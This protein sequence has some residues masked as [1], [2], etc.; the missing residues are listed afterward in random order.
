M[1]R[2]I[3]TFSDRE[4]DAAALA[5]FESQSIA[6]QTV[7]PA[8]GYARV[9]RTAVV[10]SAQD[11]MRLYERNGREFACAGWAPYRDAEH[12]VP[13]ESPAEYEEDL[14]ERADITTIETC[15]ANP[16]KMRAIAAIRGDVSRALPYLNAILPDVSY[17]H[18]MPVLTFMDAYRMVSLYPQRVSVARS[19]DIVD[20]WRVLERL[21]CAV[22]QA[23]A[24]RHE[25]EPSYTLRVKPP[26]LE[27]FKRLPGT[28]CRA[29]GEAT[30][31]A[32]AAKVYH[33]QASPGQCAPVFGADAAFAR[34]REPLS[35]ICKGLGVN[36]W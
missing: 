29:C 30:C 1:D 20:T 28:N 12:P 17:N 18:R 14:F 11:R 24:R 35:E 19:D 2:L 7:S 9:G 25:I 3:T 13:G 34:L 16:D 31:M 36:P 32:F 15:V 33:G 5:V 26:P 27:I 21:R 4:Q 23:W 10:V 22:N 6:F 8:P